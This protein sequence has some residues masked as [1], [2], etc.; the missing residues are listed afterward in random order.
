VISPTNQRQRP[1]YIQV[2]PEPL[3]ISNCRLIPF[4]FNHEPL[5]TMSITL[6]LPNRE[7]TLT[8]HRQRWA[9]V[10]HD[11]ELAKLSQR[12]E[13]NAYGQIVMSPPPSG[14][15]S[16]RQ[17]RIAR[18]L[19]RLLGE[20][21]LTECPVITQDGTKA[22]DAAW[23]SP[24]RFLEVRGQD[25]FEIAPEICVEVLSPSNTPAEMQN[26]RALYFD[27]GALECWQCDLEGHMTHYHRDQPEQ[28]KSASNL[29]PSFP[30]TISD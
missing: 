3:A 8:F 2:F 24:Q 30:G 16:T 20:Q 1:T 6:H 5:K 23:Y 9:E 4:D 29:C 27:A 26:K 17:Y 18:E 15:H 28:P 25:A 11:A 12:I 21:S 7:E 10:L 14:S 19:E 13:T 22:I